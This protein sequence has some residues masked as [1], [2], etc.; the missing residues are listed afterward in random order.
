MDSMFVRRPADIPGSMQHPKHKAAQLLDAEDPSRYDFGILQHSVQG[1]RVPL[2]TDQGGILKSD[3]PFGQIVQ[4]EEIVYLPGGRSK[5]KDYTPHWIQ[6][7]G[8]AMEKTETDAATESE[9]IP[10][11]PEPDPVAEAEADARVEEQRRRTQIEALEGTKKQRV[12]EAELK[13]IM[14]SAGV[15]TPEKTNTEGKVQARETI[16]IKMSGVFGSYKGHCFSYQAEDN[17]VVL[18]Y[19]SETETFSP[20]P[21]PTPFRLSCGK[22]NFDVYFAGIEFELPVFGCSVQV[23]IRSG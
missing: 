16:R 17:M 8:V 10:L 9:T 6:T 23:M 18:I 13:R 22:E 3:N 15:L 21:S 4:G 7:K 1:T 19:D 5:S 20:P 11:A 14:E 2:T 12:A